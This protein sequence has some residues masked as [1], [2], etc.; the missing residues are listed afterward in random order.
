MVLTALRGALGFLTRLPVGHDDRSWEAFRTTPAS[1]PLAGYVIG[2]LVAL[3][4]LLPV[5]PATAGVLYAI[6][7][8]GLTGVA[9]IDG[10]A[11]L[12]DAMAVHGDPAA[13]SR[14]MTDTAVGAG[15]VLFVAVVVAG[16]VIAGGTI[17]GRG[18]GLLAVV[19]AAEVAA[20]LGMA[21]IACVGEATHEGLGSALADPVGRRA[22][23]APALVATPAILL[24]WPRVGPAAAA[25]VAGLVGALLV[26]TWAE[27]RLGGMSGDVLGAANEVAR[28]VGLHA[29]VVVWTLS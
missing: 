19:V 3:P 26:F 14:A 12:G 15:G 21:G 2:G 22:V 28:V 9:H 25:L 10:L 7:L 20:K 17:A 23:L 29:G 4:L 18:V 27:S 1:L 11:D 13:R 16:V 6:V 8:Y 24:D 5:P